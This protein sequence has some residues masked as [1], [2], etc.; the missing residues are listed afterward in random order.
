M[1][2][3][4]TTRIQ[5]NWQT[6]NHS[7]FFFISVTS[8]ADVNTLGRSLHG[9]DWFVDPV[10]LIQ[11]PKGQKIQIFFKSLWSFWENSIFGSLGGLQNLKTTLPL[12]NLERNLV[13][14]LWVSM[15]CCVN[16]GT[17]L[18][19]PAA[20]LTSAAHM[21]NCSSLRSPGQLDC[22]N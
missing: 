4:A 2:V 16:E 20:L 3:T 18:L 7:I 17:E 19:L 11:Q 6:Q 5:G 15:L 14:I 8:A 9:G 13:Y 10:S 12:L 21:W 1:L 22:R